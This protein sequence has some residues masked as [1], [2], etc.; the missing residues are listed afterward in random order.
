M[1]DNDQVLQ[2][3]SDTALW[4]ATYR[5][6]ETDRADAHFRDP[7][8]RNLAGER[9]QEMVRK[10]PGAQRNAWAMIVRTCVFDEVIMRLI[11][12][13]GVDVVMN[14]AAGLDTRPYRL[15]LPESLSWFEID[16]PP[17]LN[18]K[19]EKLQNEKPGCRLE[20]IKM[21]L[22]DVPA[23]R[24]VF[25]R[26]VNSGKQTLILTE[27]LL[28]YLSRDQVIALANDLHAQENFRW[29]MLDFVMPRL[30]KMLLKTWDKTLTAANSRMQF[31]PEEGLDFYRNL[32]WRVAE[33]H[34]TWE[35]A[36]RLD[37]RMP[38]SGLW[39]L[40]IKLRSKKVQQ[41]YLNMAAN[42]LLERNE[43]PG[44]QA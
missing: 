26:I 2:N 34:G 7:F 43:S 29:W 17:I 15:P 33:F 31:A 21:D 44:R 19:E 27:G 13:N 38:L 14:L 3:I 28:V 24:E 23:R 8:A 42:V 18:Y 6:I 20:R 11:L 9:G 41:E 16:F 22:S 32:G 36:R 5:A 40:L 30:L 35:D 12:E 25:A 10:I 39:D 4:V 37:R 1:A